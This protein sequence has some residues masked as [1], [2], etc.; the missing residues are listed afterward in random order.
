MKDG[1]PLIALFEII[2]K[3]GLPQSIMHVWFFFLAMLGSWMNPMGSSKK[4]R[5]SLMLVYGGFYWVLAEFIAKQTL[6]G[7]NKVEKFSTM[8]AVV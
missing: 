6:C 7:C 2:I 1:N 8:G 5:L 3:L 4:C